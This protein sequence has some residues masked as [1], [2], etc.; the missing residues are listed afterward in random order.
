MKSVSL[1][2]GYSSSS[3]FSKLEAQ[4]TCRILLDGADAA[5]HWPCSTYLAV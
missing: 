1:S 2:V 3:R 5:E 4:I